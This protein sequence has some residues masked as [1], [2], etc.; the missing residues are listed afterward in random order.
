MAHLVRIEAL[1]SVVEAAGLAMA[2]A[3]DQFE[4]EPDRLIV[5]IGAQTPS[6]SMDAGN[7][8]R[9]WAR[10]LFRDSFPE[11]PSRPSTI[12]LWLTGRRTR[13]VAT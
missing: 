12:K 8:S 11:V 3:A 2:P 7:Y 9:S 1:R 4:A 13:V 5:D 6:I 10:P